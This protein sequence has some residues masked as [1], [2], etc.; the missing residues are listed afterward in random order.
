[1]GRK[2]QYLYISA[3]VPIYYAWTGSQIV[4][5]LEVNNIREHWALLGTKC[6]DILISFIF[7]FSQTVLSE[8][9]A[10]YI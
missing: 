4:L 8:H 7:T 9:N 5:L 3:S 6:S 1:M 2:I 10:M